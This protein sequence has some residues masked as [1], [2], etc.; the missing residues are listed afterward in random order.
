MQ[1]S[2]DLREYDERIRWAMFWAI[3]E[4]SRI[5]PRLLMLADRHADHGLLAAVDMRIKEL[6]ELKSPKR[7]V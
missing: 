7:S 2:S 3:I 1:D 6:Q 4:I 5:L